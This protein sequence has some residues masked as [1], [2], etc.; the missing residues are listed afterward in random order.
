LQAFMTASRQSCAFWVF[1]IFVIFTY[2]EYFLLLSFYFTLPLFCCCC[3]S[4]SPF[5]FF[6]CILLSTHRDSIMSLFHSS[7]TWWGIFVKVYGVIPTVAASAT[8]AALVFLIFVMH[9]TLS[10][11][12]DANNKN[13]HNGIQGGT[14]SE[15]KKR[16]RKGPGARHRSGSTRI[17]QPDSS[18]SKAASVST[19]S[20]KT[21]AAATGT[22]PDQPNL[23]LGEVTEDPTLLPS[24]MPLDVIA[25]LSTVSMSSATTTST[26]TTTLKSNYQRRVRAPSDG[27]ALSDDLSCESTSVR[28][29]PSLSTSSYTLG[30]VDESSF[31]I[32][33]KPVRN[34]NQSGKSGN[35]NPN[36]NANAN[37][38]TPSTSSSSRRQ[39]LKIGGGGGGNKKS[40]LDRPNKSTATELPLVASSRWDALKPSP[41]HHQQQ[42][43]S[44][45]GGRRSGSGSGINKGGR[46]HVPPLPL[47]SGSDSFFPVLMPRP[48]MSRP[49]RH[50]F[51]L[52]LT[53]HP[54]WLDFPSHP[55]AC[56]LLRTHR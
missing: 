23:V 11:R 27:S 4:S 7:T 35:P 43:K 48:E 13:S 17:N 25:P 33:T 10:P 32:E 34:T 26:T 54:M 45:S 24:S 44:N 53:G 9:R 1:S 19:M 12:R 20:A 14:S 38:A 18:N 15:K 42:H 29:V 22:R 2:H 52:L 28:S 46:V 39:Q 36:A 21:L 40:T 37:T 6:A 55:L 51:Y 8:F 16:K 49:R 31:T 50:R 56:L 41:N 30:S 47:P 3:V 5:P